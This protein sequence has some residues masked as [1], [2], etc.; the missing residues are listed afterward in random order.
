MSGSAT[1][2]VSG[3]PGHDGSRQ[4]KG[5]LP[6]RVPCGL[7]GTRTGVGKAFEALLNASHRLDW[8]VEMDPP[9]LVEEHPW[10][11]QT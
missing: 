6:C 9:K 7:G 10:V 5:G 11:D 1:Q 3:R 8:W 2:S 4:G